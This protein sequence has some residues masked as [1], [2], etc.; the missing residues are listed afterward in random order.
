MSNQEHNA[1]SLEQARALDKFHDRFDHQKSPDWLSDEAKAEEKDYIY[2]LGSH[3]AEL[4]KLGTLMLSEPGTRMV[5]PA[6]EAYKLL[7]WLYDNHRNTLYKLT[8]QHQN[9]EP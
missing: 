9:Q 3:T 6:E 5:L 7:I 1:Y 8:H 2:N 4:N